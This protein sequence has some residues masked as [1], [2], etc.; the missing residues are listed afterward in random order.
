MIISKVAQCMLKCTYLRTTT[1]NEIIQNALQLKKK[2][3]GKKA[4]TKTQTMIVLKVAQCPLK[5]M[6][7]HEG[8]SSKQNLL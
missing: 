5:C 3:N 8:M 6:N 1:T 4:Y 7:I 2:G